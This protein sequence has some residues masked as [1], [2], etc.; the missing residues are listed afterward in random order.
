MGHIHR[1]I[2]ISKA[3]QVELLVLDVDGVLTDGRIVYTS[4]GDQ[5]LAFHVHDGL[6]IKLVAGCGVKVAIISA[7]KGTALERRAAELG[8]DLLFQGVS[9]KAVCL[10]KLLDNLGLVREQVAAVGD[11]WVDLPV[12]KY[13]GLSVI[14]RDAA[15]N[16]SDYVDYVTEKPGGAGAVREVCELILKAKKKWAHCFDK[17]LG[18]SA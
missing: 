18:S 4:R 7:R 15:S 12:L 1:D 16:M 10:E 9:D 11:D 6:G 14:V 2:L 5:I 17:F 3:A 13:V 8:I